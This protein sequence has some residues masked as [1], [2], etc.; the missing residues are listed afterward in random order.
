MYTGALPNGSWLIKKLMP[1]RAEL[2]IIATILTLAH[3]IS[4]GMTYFK[5]LFTMPKVMPLNQILATIC[6]MVMMCIM[7]PLCITSF[8]S[9]RKKMNPK[10]WK[11]LQRWAYVFKDGEGLSLRSQSHSPPQRWCRDRTYRSGS[12]VSGS[13]PTAVPGVPV[14]IMPS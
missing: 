5:M 2:S 9:I 12:A 4:Y 14:M 13:V 3:N 1:V 7:I 10:S 11:K 6:T 8:K